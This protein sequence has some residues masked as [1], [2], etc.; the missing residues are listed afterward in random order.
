LTRT[1][2]GRAEDIAGDA[3]TARASDETAQ[4]MTCR[5]AVAPLAAAAWRG[6]VFEGVA[7]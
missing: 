1:F 7:V 6:V 4:S 5:D 3:S 2:S